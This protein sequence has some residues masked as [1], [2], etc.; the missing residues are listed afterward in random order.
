M[1]GHSR[2]LRLLLLGG[3]EEARL[4]AEAI[5]LRYGD[6][7]ALLTSLAGRTEMPA[8]LPGRVRVGGFGG[9][10]GLVQYL[11]EE[12]IELVV[13]ATHPFAARI[14]AN[15]AAAC[16]LR[17]TPL[18]ALRR[19]A[20]EC[21]PGDD[22]R[23][24]ANLAAAASLLPALGRRV[25]LTIGAQGLEAFVPLTTHWFLVRLIAPKPIA[26]MRHQ[27]VLGRGP[28]ALADELVLMR[29]HGIEV[30]VTKASGGAATAAKLSAARELGLP[31]VMVARP[32]GLNQALDDAAS[33]VES[34][35]EWIAAKLEPAHT[36]GG[37]T[38]PR[39]SGTLRP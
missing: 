10:D 5:A 13:D 22:W 24:A 21:Q 31:V 12:R 16:A 29:R 19:S 7:V 38:P 11:A 18:F 3:T 30:L 25:F 35:L 8:A 1:P 9:A 33:S 2:P 20:W 28:F 37:L 39:A 23:A 27:L 6:R 26:L 34:A 36:T 17:A 15:A 14:K 4:L 32:S